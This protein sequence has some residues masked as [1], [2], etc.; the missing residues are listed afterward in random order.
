MSGPCVSSDGRAE[1]AT[2]CPSLEY[3]GGA[4]TST[5]LSMIGVVTAA[6]GIGLAG[7]MLTTGAGAVG[8]SEAG[9][10]DPG[11][12]DGDAGTEGEV[13]P[14][15]LA[16]GAE[17][18][19]AGDADGDDAV[20]DGRGVEEPDGTGVAAGGVAPTPVTAGVGESAPGVGMEDEGAGVCVTRVSRG[21]EKA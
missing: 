16:W 12:P 6:D 17:G 2:H 4:P 21:T 3:A 14:R 1:N 18:G 11:S 7:G 15:G 5:T 8:A 10:V 20:R 13:A 9:A 19:A